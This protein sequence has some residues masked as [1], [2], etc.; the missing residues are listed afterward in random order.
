MESSLATRSSII[1]STSNSHIFAARWLTVLG[2]IE[3][4]N[5]SGSLEK[6]LEDNDMETEAATFVSLPMTF[7]LG[8]R[9]PWL[10]PQL[11]ICQRYLDLCWVV[12][13]A[14]FAACRWVDWQSPEGLIEVRVI[15]AINVELRITSSISGKALVKWS[16]LLMRCDNSKTLLTFKTRGY[17]IKRIKWRTNRS[18]N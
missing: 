17:C 8:S 3:N 5:T 14:V 7:L 11:L 6:E 10:Q 1:T 18:V 4:R 2:S 13:A 12:S 16:Q 15:S 9:S